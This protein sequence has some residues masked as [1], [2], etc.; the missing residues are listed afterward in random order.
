[1]TKQ[2]TILITGASGFIGRHLQQKLTEKGYAVRTL[3]TQIMNS[4]VEDCFYWNPDTAEINKKA[5]ESVDYIIHLAGASIGSKR[6]TKRRKQLITDSRVKSTELLFEKIKLFKIPLKGFI[7]ASATGYYG[8][9]T[10]DEI[11]DEDSPV[12]HDFLGKVCYDWEQAA[13]RFTTAGIRTVKI[14]TGVVLSKDAPALRKMLLPIKLGIG[15]P[16]GSGK[17]YMPWIHIDDLCEIYIKAIEDESFS[18]AYNAVAPQHITNRELMKTL[19]KAY[20]KPFW[21]PPVPGFILK[22]LLGEMAVIILKG[23][24]VEAKRLIEADF[25]FSFTDIKISKTV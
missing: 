14:R 20:K 12:A 9:V 23:S 6:W 10:S 8:S 7:S 19:A 18:G 15:G 1:M 22:I 5:F 17:Q 2:Q 11:F 16:I 4:N 13:D 25:Q 24:R 3:T 21:F